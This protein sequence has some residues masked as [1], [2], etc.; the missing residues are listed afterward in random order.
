MS[1]ER[2]YV[3]IDVGQSEVWA[4]VG[5]GKPRKFRHDLAGVK[6][7]YQW[8]RAKSP[9][10]L[11]HFCLEATGI[12]GHSL[13][14]RLLGLGRC[15]V[16]IVNPAQIA[17]FAKAQRRRSKTD[18]IDAQVIWA[19][20]DSLHPSAWQPEREA[21][22]TLAALV[23][24]SDA[25]RSTLRAWQNRCHTQKYHPQLPEAVRQSTAQ[26]EAMLQQQLDQLTQ[27]IHRLCQADA[28]LKRDVELLC[29]IPG[30]AELTA[31]RLLAYG[32][33][34]LTERSPKELTAHA[35]L[36]PRHRLSGTSIKGKPHLCKQGDARLRY[37]LYMPTVAATTFNPIIRHH[38]QRHLQNHKPKMVA[39]MA[40]M[41]KLL[42]MAQAILITQQPFDPCIKPLT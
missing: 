20:A 36:A 11:L 25:V 27:E 10:Q 15:D 9:D 32:K 22:Q 14:V 12:Y 4:S 42:L 1:K 3:G 23:T 38:Y 6:Q 29:T 18:A 7:L 39:L 2:F 31:T 19:F 35:G 41:K 8:S 17:A 26:V 37:L 5:S 21:I 30:V 34:S 28:Q 40:C 24:Q 13:A 16:S 33:R